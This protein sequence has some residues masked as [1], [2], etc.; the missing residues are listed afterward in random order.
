MGE[1]LPSARGTPGVGWMHVSRDIVAAC[2]EMTARHLAPRDY[3]ASWRGPL[4]FAA[5]AADDPLPGVFDVPLAVSR[6][7]TKRLPA[8]L[9]R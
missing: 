4:Q 5:F 1:A 9:R 6:L 8:A 2:Q 3:L 7:F